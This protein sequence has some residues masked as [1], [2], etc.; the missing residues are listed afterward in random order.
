MKH[1][2]VVGDPLLDL[3][4]NTSSDRRQ[5]TTYVPEHSCSVNQQS[6][7]EIWSL[8]HHENIQ[9]NFGTIKHHPEKQN[10][11][12]FMFVRFHHQNNKYDKWYWVT[13][14]KNLPHGQT[15]Q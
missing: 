3:T 1:K 8:K 15:F 6:V 12:N 10:T 7:K 13:K 2:K 9:S 14:I 5:S 11:R 4:I